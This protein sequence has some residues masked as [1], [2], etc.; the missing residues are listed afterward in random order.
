MKCSHCGADI[1]GV[2]NK[3]TGRVEYKEYVL[4]N[5]ETRCENCKEKQI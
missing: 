3:E 2:F 5:G 1:Q 4:S